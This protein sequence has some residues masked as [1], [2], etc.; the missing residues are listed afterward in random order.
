MWYWLLWARDRSL[1][2]KS[3]L[4]TTLDRQNNLQFRHVGT[5]VVPRDQ[6]VKPFLVDRVCWPWCSS[7]DYLCHS[8]TPPHL[9]SQC[10]SSRKNELEYRRVI[11][12]CVRTSTSKRRPARFLFI[13]FHPPVHCE[14]IVDLL[15]HP[16]YLS[17]RTFV[18]M[19]Y[20]NNNIKKLVQLEY[21]GTEVSDLHFTFFFF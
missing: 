8:S 13:P 9:E 3:M 19:S 20:N 2:I 21:V 12:L 5:L 14:W 6:A 15:S 1:R 17:G 11:P 10:S 4:W 18:C 7:Q 16:E